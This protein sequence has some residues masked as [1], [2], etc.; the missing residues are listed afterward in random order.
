MDL[1]RRELMQQFALLVAGVGVGACRRKRGGASKSAKQTHALKPP[2]RATL[3]AACA[4]ILPT[5]QD[6][7][8]TEANV[9][10]YIDRELAEPEYALLAKNMRAGV[11]ALDRFARRSSGGKA[12]VA[13][14]AEAQDEV[15]RRVQATSERGADFV[16]F[17]IILTLEG[18]LGDPHWGGNAGGVGW[19]LV[20]YGPGSIR[21]RRTDEEGKD[22][23]R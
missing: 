13:L 20:G 15:I 22:P 9:I 11:V 8:A 7:G 4:R 5:D 14:A 3:E 12:F 17:L 6:P 2:Q 19:K 16:R 18:F 23:R 1:A 10:E 21:G